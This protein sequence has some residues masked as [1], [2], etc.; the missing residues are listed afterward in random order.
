MYVAALGMGAGVLVEGLDQRRLV[1][2]HQLGIGTD[3]ATGEGMPWQLVEG[4]GFHVVQRTY[5]EVELAGHL[6]L[7]P[8]PSFAGL[9][10]QFTGVLASRCCYFGMRGFHRCSDRYC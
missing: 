7:R 1:H 6:G 5:G 9:A 2:V 10:Q 4:T 3:V 8:L